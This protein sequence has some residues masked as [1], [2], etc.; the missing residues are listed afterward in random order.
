M[1]ALP[2]GIPPLDLPLK[3][4]SDDQSNSLSIVFERTFIF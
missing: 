1:Q 2:S 3:M 4:I